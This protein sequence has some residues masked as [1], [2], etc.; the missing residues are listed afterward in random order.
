MTGISDAPSHADVLNYFYSL[1][2]WKRWGEDDEL[3]TLNLI[4][5]QTVQAA[6]KMAISGRRISLGRVISP[7]NTAR[8]AHPALHFMIAAGENAPSSGFGAAT[9]WF[10]LG[11]HG[12]SVTHL[13]AHSHMFWD[14]RMY[15]GNDARRVTSRGAAQGSV[16][17]ASRGFVSR[18]VLVDIPGFRGVPVLAK[19]EPIGPDELDECLVHQGANVAAG[20]VLIVRTGRDADGVADH[21][22]GD[23]AGLHAACLPWLR[24]H[25][26]SLLAADIPQEVKPSGYPEIP[27][28]IHSVGLVAMGLWLADNLYL[29]ELAAACAKARR[30]EFLFIA[31]PL[32]LKNTTGAPINPLAIL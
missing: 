30:W 16:E 26:I 1:S 5:D 21:V 7:R 27:F 25:N 8:D 15:N 4:T 22:N 2:N 10:G 18:G 12:S 28:P 11:F 13:D 29:E 20:D 9:D 6:V 17:V 32:V 14:G 19:G 23:H 24:R 3:G 31:A